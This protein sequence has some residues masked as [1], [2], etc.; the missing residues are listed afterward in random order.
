MMHM[1]SGMSEK[2]AEEAL[3]GAMRE[4]CRGG[5]WEGV[6]RGVAWQAISTDSED[7]RSIEMLTE[8]ADAIF[9]SLID[10][11]L[12]AVE[13]VAVQAWDE[14]LELRAGDREGAL[15]AAR[16]DAGDESIQLVESAGERVLETLLAGIRHAA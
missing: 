10:E 2:I 16:L 8:A 14:F 13:R 15:T 1:P 11:A 3:R 12:W 9:A 5:S 4:L 6:V 7:P